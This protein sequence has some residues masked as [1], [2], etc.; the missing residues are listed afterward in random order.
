[1]VYLSMAAW[2][3]QLFQPYWLQTSSFLILMNV[4]ATMA[5][6]AWAFPSLTP[7]FWA[8]WFLCVV[9]VCAHATSIT[10][11]SIAFLNLLHLA[12]LLALREVA[13]RLSLSPRIAM[14]L[15]KLD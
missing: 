4:I 2:L 3:T 10:F 7:F 12:S 14:P 6:D 15:D 1:M 8:A 9:C 5:V 11:S 13:G